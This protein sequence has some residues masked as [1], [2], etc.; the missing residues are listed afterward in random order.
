[1][2]QKKTEAENLS[3]ENNEPDYE[4]DGE[5]RCLEDGVEPEW[6]WD[7]DQRCWVCSGCG[8]TC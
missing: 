4:P 3:E 5:C 2:K 6:Q 1:M 7:K 8:E